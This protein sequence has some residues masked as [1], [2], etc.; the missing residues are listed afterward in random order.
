MNVVAHTVRLRLRRYTPEDAA[1]LTALLTDPKTMRH[2]P[3]P[4]TS[5]QARAWHQRALDAHAKP[6]LGRLAVELTDGTYIGDAGIV[7][8]EILGRA[9]NDLGYIIAHP[10][11]RTGYGLEAA[12]ACFE[13]GRSAG[14]RRIVANMAADNHGSVRVAQRLGFTF[15]DSLAQ[16]AR[17]RQG[18]AAVRVECALAQLAQLG[19]A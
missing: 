14:H 1:E 13:F 16:S 17:P 8:A 18:D 12:Q 2:W 5:E 15:G 4:L 11:W 10:F 9:E 7:H 3:E 19:V 6:G